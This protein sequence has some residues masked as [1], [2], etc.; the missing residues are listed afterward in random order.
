MVGEE[1][2]SVL[3]NGRAVLVSSAAVVV[4]GMRGFIVARIGRGVE[5]LR[6]SDAFFHGRCFPMLEQM[7]EGCE[8]KKHDADLNEEHGV[9][10]AGHRACWYSRCSLLSSAAA[11][12]EMADQIKS[13]VEN[14]RPSTGSI[15]AR[16]HFSSTVA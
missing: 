4:A 16:S 6:L 15:G 2:R 1:K 5:M 11:A 10:G 13:S 8:A 12:F 7:N 14:F 9:F 3:Q